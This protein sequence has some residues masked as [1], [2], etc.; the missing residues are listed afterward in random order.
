MGV[1]CPLSSPFVILFSTML[2]AYMLFKVFFSRMPNSGQTLA[3]VSKRP[4]VAVV[5]IRQT[6][7]GIQSGINHTNSLQ[8]SNQE[9]RLH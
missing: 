1:L 7:I 6:F 4:I 5:K 8:K 3:R 2:F 9:I